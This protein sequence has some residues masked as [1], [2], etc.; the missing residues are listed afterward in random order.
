M[1][2]VRGR[3]NS[4]LFWMTTNAKAVAKGFALCAGKPSDSSL[5]Y[6]GMGNALRWPRVTKT[7]G[8]RSPGMRDKVEPPAVCRA[9]G[10]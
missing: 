4:A 1:S 3:V 8:A 9:P 5:K 2:L 10:P 7:P 6:G